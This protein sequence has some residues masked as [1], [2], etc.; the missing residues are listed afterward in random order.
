MFQLLIEH[1]FL[2]TCSLNNMLLIASTFAVNF[3]KLLTDH[4]EIHSFESIGNEATRKE[5]F[6]SHFL[7]MKRK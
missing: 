5:K 1:V 3:Q 6:Y 7:I 2:E 4:V